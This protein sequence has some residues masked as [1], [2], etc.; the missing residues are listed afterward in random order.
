MEATNEIEEKVKTLSTLATAMSIYNL[1]YSLCVSGQNAYYQ[2]K[3]YH[4]GCQNISTIV[5]KIVRLACFEDEQ[6]C[7]QNLQHEWRN[8]PKSIGLIRISFSY[9]QRFYTEAN[10]LPKFNEFAYAKFLEILQTKERIYHLFCGDQSFLD[11]LKSVVA[12]SSSEIDDVQIQCDNFANSVIS[13]YTNFANGFSENSEI[14][15]SSPNI[16]ESNENNFDEDTLRSSNVSEHL[17]EAYRDWRIMHD[18]QINFRKSNHLSLTT[19]IEKY[20][21]HEPTAYLRGLLCRSGKRN[22]PSTKPGTIGFSLRNALSALFESVTSDNKIGVQDELQDY[23]IVFEDWFLEYVPEV[24]IAISKIFFDGDTLTVCWNNPID[25][26]S[27]GVVKNLISKYNEDAI[28]ILKVPE[29]LTIKNQWVELLSCLQSPFLVSAKYNTAMLG[30]TG[31]ILYY[32]DKVFCITAFHAI[33]RLNSSAEAPF[34]IDVYYSSSRCD[35]T[36]HFPRNVLTKSFGNCIHLW[37][38]FGLDVAIIK[39][40]D[41]RLGF[42]V[43]YVGIDFPIQF[44]EWWEHDT[45]KTI[46]AKVAQ[47][48]S[49]TLVKCGISSNVT[50]GTVV[51]MFGGML[52][53]LGNEFTPF[54]SPGDSGSVVSNKETGDFIGILVSRLT[55]EEVDYGLVVPAWT[56]KSFFTD[57]LASF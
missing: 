5:E 42:S 31:T 53:V 36:N 30:G 52:Q 4:F 2:D 12:Q 45:L 14:R 32:E 40:R 49:F 29:G 8:L 9:L 51:G 21:Q 47:V 6:S 28:D 20:L 33:Q 10:S 46:T 44:N 39:P 43:N 23:K 50:T 41:F 1:V 35:F 22:N 55:V 54:A 34:D 15:V 7:L 57:A 18:W 48:K 26:I 38:D 37:V 24:P 16:A 56:M 3:L 19:F 17:I 25:E 13:R 11:D 27:N